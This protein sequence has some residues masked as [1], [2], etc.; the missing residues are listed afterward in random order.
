MEQNKHENKQFKRECCSKASI[1][2][3]QRTIFFVETN[4]NEIMEIEY[5]IGDLVRCKNELSTY[6]QL[7][8]RAQ[9]YIQQTKQNVLNCKNQE[10]KKSSSLKTIFFRQVYVF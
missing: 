2:L 9:A 6:K 8:T 7:S 3:A 5:F 10:R 1:L 4:W